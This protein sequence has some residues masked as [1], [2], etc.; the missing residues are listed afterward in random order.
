MKNELQIL[1]DFIHNLTWEQVPVQ[2]QEAAAFR[3][4]D[5]VSGALGAS[6]EDGL[7]PVIRSYMERSGALGDSEHGGYPRNP[8]E[9]GDL[10]YSGN[11]PC[12]IW[13]RDQTAPLETAARINAMLAHTLE[14]DDVHSASKTHGS[15][16]FIPAAWAA[17]EYLGCTG[18]EFLL[19][20][21]CGYE[22]TARIGMAM[23]VSAHRRL[24][25][26]ATSTCGIFGCAGAVGKLLH[27]T[28]EELASA[29]GM[30]GTQSSGRWA[31]LEDGSTCKVLHVAHSAACGMDA[32]FLAK[33]GMTGPEH[34]LEASDGGLFQVMADEGDLTAVARGLGE[35]WE[36]LNVDVKPYPCCRSTHCA[37]DG[38]LIL[39]ERMEK[40]GWLADQI[41]DIEIETY[42]VGYRQCGKTPGCVDPKN[43]QD[44]KFSTPYTVAAAL[45]Y[46][47]VT[48]NEFTRELVDDPM[49]RRLIQ[50]VSV[51]PVERFTREYPAH[52]GCSVKIRF[53]DGS[54]LQETVEDA[55]GSIHRPL[56][57]EQLMKKAEGL[58]EGLYPG[59]TKEIA[60]KI[61]GIGSLF[62][63][64]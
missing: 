1:A 5:L 64:S 15:A 17:A 48:R 31:F 39:R 24:G 21:I 4:L 37:I 22:I 19:A 34:I 38:A 23:G 12:H 11:G 35:T 30:A 53:Q 54:I 28:G 44:A 45:L 2:V 63:Y 61:L 41:Q 49:M 6:A 50:R 56:T 57:R 27:L 14:L 3:V 62:P 25:W 59:K 16:S 29:F 46:G 55:S 60:E 18:E 40:E 47:R 9:F 36:I 32:A 43:T 26:H 8:G 20:V 33:A 51:T 52:W 13:G 10:K 42:E 7:D 58:M